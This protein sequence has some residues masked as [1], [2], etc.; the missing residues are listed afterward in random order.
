MDMKLYL[1]ICALLNLIHCTLLILME[2]LVP[3]LIGRGDSQPNITHIYF[4]RK[5]VLHYRSRQRGSS[6]DMYE[7]GYICGS[8]AGPGEVLV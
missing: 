6:E 4:L 7:E 5:S 1:G 2:N 8:I 3:W